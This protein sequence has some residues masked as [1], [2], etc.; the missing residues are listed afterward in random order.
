MTPDVALRLTYDEWRAILDRE[1]HV[2]VV[3]D[4]GHRRCEQERCLSSLLTRAE[5]E[6][7]YAHNSFIRRRPE[8]CA[9]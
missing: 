4:E 1:L 9:G 2:V 5:A 7:Y 3:D 8:A 6:S